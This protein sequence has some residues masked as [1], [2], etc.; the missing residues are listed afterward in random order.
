MASI[1]STWEKISWTWQPASEREAGDSI[2]RNFL[3]HWFPAKV[4][5]R[6]LSVSYSYWLG[7]ISAVVFFILSVTGVVLMFLYVP[8]IERAYPSI[9]DLEYAVSFGWFIRALHRVAAH[10]M[11]AAVF[12][13]MIRVFLTGAYRNTTLT[14]QNRPLNWMTVVGT[15][16]RG[17]YWNFYLPWET[18]PEMPS[19]F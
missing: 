12:L 1:K 10:L 16:M 19:S 13:H 9:K 4:T 5:K 6:S 14:N 3:L 17:P 7:T 15:F 2:V 11:V 18:W 8:S